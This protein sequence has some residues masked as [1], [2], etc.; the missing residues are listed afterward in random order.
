MEQC[1]TWPSGEGQYRYMHPMR[2]RAVWVQNHGMR[3]LFNGG[4]VFTQGEETQSV[5]R[6]RCAIK[7]IQTGGC[8]AVVCGSAKPGSLAAAFSRNSMAIGLS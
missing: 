7:W 8:P 2:Y 4:C 6:V 3:G 1:L 5:G